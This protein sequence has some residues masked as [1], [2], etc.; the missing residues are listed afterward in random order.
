ME[1]TLRSRISTMNLSSSPRMHLKL[2]VRGHRPESSISYNDLYSAIS[3]L[4]LH[5]F[6]TIMIPPVLIVAK[7]R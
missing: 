1:P 4:S 6:G 5:P 7:A 3:T 2:A